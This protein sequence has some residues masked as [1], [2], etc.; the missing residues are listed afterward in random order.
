MSDPQHDLAQLSD[1]LRYAKL[2]VQ[3]TSNWSRSD[4]A[5]DTI[6]GWSLERAVE[7]VG[8]AARGVTV[9]FREEHPGIPWKQ[10]IATRHI[11][12]HDYGRV[13]YEILW[14]IKTIHLPELI[15]QVE[16]LIPLPPAVEPEP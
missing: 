11:M 7:I 6:N 9:K 12:A 4:V 10:I 8:E 15:R 1:M 16:A 3:L 2:V 14:R 13:N 5:P